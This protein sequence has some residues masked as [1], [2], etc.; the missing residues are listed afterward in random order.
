VPA[1]DEASEFDTYERALARGDSGG[2]MICGGE[3]R[4]PGSFPVVIARCEV[5]KRMPEF[6]TILSLC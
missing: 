1:K 2:V 4:M 5:D 6:F 3:R